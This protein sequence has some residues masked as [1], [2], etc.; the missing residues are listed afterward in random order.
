MS[1]DLSQFEGLTPGKWERY[2]DIGSGRGLDKV[3]VVVGHDRIG[4]PQFASIP[5]NEHDA[6]AI[7]SLPAL[8]ADLRAAR[9]ALREIDA[10]L[11]AVLDLQPRSVRVCEG[12]GPEN[13]AASIAVTVAGLRAAL[14]PFGDAFR[15]SAGSDMDDPTL[16]DIDDYVETKDW[17]RAAELTEARAALKE[18]T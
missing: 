17:K 2:G 4:R 13:L 3:R 16:P 11:I 8:L 1:V 10:E 6:K 15:Q 14:K 9:E 7:A 18:G 12:L 5:A